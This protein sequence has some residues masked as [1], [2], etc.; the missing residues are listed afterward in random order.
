MNTPKILKHALLIAICL[1]SVACKKTFDITP[2]N[3]ITPENAYRDVN[4]ADAAIFGILGKFVG[5]MDRFVV[6]NELRGDLMDVTQNADKYLKQL[7]EH[8]VTTDNPWADPKPYFSIILNCNDVMNNFNAMLQDK[9]MSQANYNIRYSEVAGIWAWVYLQLG[10]HYGSVPYV[11][12]SLSSIEELNDTSKYPMVTFD[13]LLDK[14]INVI[15]NV[16]VMLPIQLIG[17]GG[18]TAI[19]VPEGLSLIRTIDGYST[20]RMFINRPFLLGDLYLWKGNYPMAAHNYRIV[21]NYAELIDPTKADVWLQYMKEYPSVN[22]Y[23]GSRTPPNAW[24]QMFNSPYGN[25]DLTDILTVLPFDRNFAPANPFVTLF[26]HGGKYL[27]KPSALAI[28]NWNSQT[29]SD[30]TPGDTFRGAGISYST[31][32][33]PE[34]QKLLGQYSP[35][36]PFATNGKVILQRG[37]GIL[38]HL[39]ETANRDGRDQLTSGILN[40][41]FLN[42][43]FKGPPPIPTNVVNIEQN[44][45]PNPDYYF[46]ARFGQFPAFAG[47][48]ERFAGMR[49]H[50]ALA[51]NLVDSTKYFDMSNPGL[52]DKPVTN[53]KGLMLVLEDKIVDENGL[54]MAYEGVRWSDLLRVA[55]R[56]EKEAPGTGLSFLRNKIASKF[57]AAGLPIPDSVN[58]LGASTSNW[59]M[60]F[61]L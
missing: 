52:W 44:F 11:T 42:G 59:Y 2:E 51:Q 30:G 26:S 18:R 24:P 38:M 43:I 4:D 37:G 46:D 19:N 27:L 12:S 48:W 50:V 56:R 1:C 25:D 54:E 49:G 3:V 20:A 60:P 14:L 53:A 23:D 21:H 57:V 9:R 45:D 47:S 41:G 33:E 29:R 31:G 28:K 39:A 17:P 5:V 10:I 15:Q 13:Q 6:Q 61:K 55:L 22:G 58:K 40:T 34:V 36:N 35:A 8:N 16:P 7:N 32:A